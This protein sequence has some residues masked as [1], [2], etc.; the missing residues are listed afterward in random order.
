MAITTFVAPWAK[1]D[2]QI[3]PWRRRS[4]RVRQSCRISRRVTRRAPRHEPR[5][6]AMAAI[7]SVSPK[8]RAPETSTSVT[9]YRTA[10]RRRSSTDEGGVEFK[11]HHFVLPAV[12]YRR[13]NRQSAVLRYA[14]QIFGTP[15]I[16]IGYDRL[17]EGAAAS[18]PQQVLALLP[19]SYTLLLRPASAQFPIAACL[20]DPPCTQTSKSTPY[21]PWSL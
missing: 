5:R 4:S 6:N 12:S 21:C 17:E 9:L 7:A 8:H 18:H 3:E 16:A 20:S 11:A 1:T 19:V 14:A 15:A 13:R 10:L 2:C